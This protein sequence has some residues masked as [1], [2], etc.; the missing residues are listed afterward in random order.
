MVDPG[1]QILFH[2]YLV[3]LAMTEVVNRYKKCDTFRLVRWIKWKFPSL[4]EL[5]SNVGA[6]PKAQLQGHCCWM[7]AWETV[8]LLPT[9]TPHCPG[10][11]TVGHKSGCLRNTQC[12]SL[13][14]C[15]HPKNALDRKGNGACHPPKPMRCQQGFNL[16]RIGPWAT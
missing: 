5:E 1:H 12:K 4:T 10:Q 14:C 13:K 15:D 8:S 3:W 7:Q 11:K 9:L 6:A 16:H 2:Q